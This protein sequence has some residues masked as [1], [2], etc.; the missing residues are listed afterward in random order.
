MV[1]AKRA[2]KKKSGNKKRERK[3]RRFVPEQIYASKPSVI[4]GMAGALALGAGVFGQWFSETPPAYAP[5]L[6]AS[7]ALALGAALWFGDAGAVPIR[8]G[9]AGIAAE[10]GNEMTRLAWCDLERI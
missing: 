10:R 3:E 5:Y 7:G 9:D 2:K 8:V 4:G 1:E 6:F